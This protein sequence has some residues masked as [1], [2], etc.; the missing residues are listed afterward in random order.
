M[1]DWRKMTESERRA[2]LA[3]RQAAELPWHS[4]PHRKC[5]G[6]HGFILAAACY[7]H[8]PIIGHS[9]SRM[10]AC[11]R[12]ILCVCQ[13]SASEVYAWCVL[14]NH[15]HVLLRTDRIAGL[16]WQLGRFHG[17]SSHAWN[18]EEGTRGRKVW[19]NCLERSMRS[20]RHFFASLNCVHQ[21][22]VH[23]GYVASWADWPWSSASWFLEQVG[24]EQA[25]RIWR[26]YPILDYG[27]KWDMD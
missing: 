12:E 20:E 18:A 8:A 4:P 13:Q 10:A 17:R 23:H 21:N 25:E 19:C 22:A 3:H 24:R 2:V 11:E 5:E 9:P 7:E 14:P 6:A 26:E 27:K 16:R 15:Y 1:Y